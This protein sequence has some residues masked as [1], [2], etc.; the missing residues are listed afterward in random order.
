MTSGWVHEKLGDAC[1]L[2][3]RGISPV[4]VEGNGLTILNQKCIRNHTISIGPA[5]KHNAGLKKVAEEK[6]LRIGDVLVNSTGE[7]TL[8]RVAQVRDAALEGMTV[9]SHVSIVRPLQ[10]KFNPEFFGYALVLIEKEIQESGSGASGQTELARTVL[11]NNFSI[12]YP[13]SLSEQQR[14]VAILDEAFAAIDKAKANA[15]QNLRNAKEFF[16]SYLQEQYTHLFLTGER[17]I[18]K[19][20]AQVIGGYSFKSSAFNKSGKYQVIR[21][22][23]V[24]P[25]V[26][27]EAESP[28]FIN[29]LDKKALIKA[30]LLPNDII[31]TQT[32]TK[33]KR[34]YG[35]TVL[36]EKENYLLNQR[37]ATIRFSKKYLPKFFLYFSWTDLFK[38]QFFA[39]EN[40]TVGQGNVGITAVKDAEIPN[41]SVEEQNL[42]IE[43]I[44]GITTESQKLEVIY[45]KKIKHLE[46]LK[47]SILKKAFTGE[48]K[49]AIELV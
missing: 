48:L 13:I 43:R 33:K 47:K 22:G 28:V 37:I 39:K 46:E 21:M 2:I 6:L 32:G 1:S 17:K 36:I 31:I 14:I 49:T 8:G 5:R 30:L 38:D 4:Y 12:R 24:R 40:G 27:R 11:Q 26:I 42:I 9:D 10:N 18:I 23:N 7:G 35:Y 3:T 34:D 16:E 44:E 20:V 25:G 29:K 41:V 15:E 45:C 19:D